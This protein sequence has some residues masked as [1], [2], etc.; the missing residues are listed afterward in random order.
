[1]ASSWLSQPWVWATGRWTVVRGSGFPAQ[2]TPVAHVVLSKG[3]NGVL[4]SFD[5][6]GVVSTSRSERR[7]GVVRGT[8]ARQPLAPCL[9]RLPWPRGKENTVADECYFLVVQSGI[10]CCQ[11]ENN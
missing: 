5:V 6:T 11:R 10:L 2:G 8:A 3:G 1:M 7:T 4:F 9:V